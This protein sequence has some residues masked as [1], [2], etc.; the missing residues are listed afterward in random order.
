M[1]FI[2]LDNPCKMLGTYL[3]VSQAPYFSCQSVM[4]CFMN[5]MLH[6]F[7]LA[8]NV[9]NICFLYVKLKQQKINLIK[10]LELKIPFLF[11]VSWERGHHASEI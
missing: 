2:K 3:I 8:I 7:I 9:D 10:N 1:V 6:N 4:S 11:T 5:Q